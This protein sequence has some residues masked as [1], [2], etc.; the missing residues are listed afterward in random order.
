MLHPVE[1]YGFNFQINHKT[2]SFITDTGYFPE[3]PDRFRGEI[4]IINVLLTERKP[5]VFH[6]SVPEVEDI[7]ARS[8]PQKVI[9]THFGRKM[10]TAKPNEVAGRLSQKFG[11]EVIAATDGMMIEF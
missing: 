9:L 5:E 7:L 8:K 6:L 3:I 11:I 10:L 4:M 2:V 1:T